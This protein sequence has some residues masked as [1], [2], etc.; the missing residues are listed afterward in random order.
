MTIGWGI[1][2]KCSADLLWLLLTDEMNTPFRLKVVL[3]WMGN[4]VSPGSFLVH[5]YPLKENIISNLPPKAKGM[6]EAYPS[7]ILYR[8]VQKEMTSQACNE[9]RMLQCDQQFSKILFFF[10][11]CNYIICLL[12]LRKSI[13]ITQTDA[14][15][16]AMAWFDDHRVQDYQDFRVDRERGLP[17]TEKRNRRCQPRRHNT[18][19]N[20]K[21]FHI[22]RYSA[23]ENL[24]AYPLSQKA[25]RHHTFFISVSNFTSRTYIAHKLHRQPSTKSSQHQTLV[26]GIHH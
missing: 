8:K 14:M 10:W 21:P 11:I 9:R 20:T 26:P 18:F 1:N 17:E 23:K 13:E 3:T 22:L 7:Q 2:W 6:M 19:F 25:R 5:V 16:L 24:R 15:A 4:R 12:L